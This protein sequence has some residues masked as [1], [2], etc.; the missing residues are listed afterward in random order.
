MSVPT[1]SLPSVALNQFSD[2]VRAWFLDTF[3]APTSLQEQ[4]WEAIERGE[5]ALVIAPTGSGKTLAAFLFAIDSLM[6]EKAALDNA[7]EGEPVSKDSCCT[8]E[9]RPL[10]GVRVVY[11]SPLKALGADVER[12]L[13]DPL[14]GIVERLAR[15]GVK[16]PPIR[17][18]MRTGD[19]TPVQRRSIVRNPPDILITT[20]ESLYLMLTSQAREVLRSVETVIVDEVHALAGNKR[21]AHLALSLERLDDLLKQPAQRI[22]LSATVRPREEVAHFLGGP[23]VVRVVASEVKPDMDVRVSVPVRD[24]TA[25]PAFQ[26][27]DAKGSEGTLPRGL[28]SQGGRAGGIRHIPAEA[29]W[30]SDRTLRAAMDKKLSS[31]SDSRV[32]SSSIWPYI[33]SAILDEVLAHRSTIVFVNSRGL[34]EKLTARLNE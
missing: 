1:T 20:P 32:G 24:M 17:T 2:A 23:H 5:N 16:A 3:A 7:F 15:N 8:T 30:K 28:I 31:P 33:E 21:G 27:F 19:T 14:S 13:Q 34:C 12:N 4:A 6:R 10:K 11:I 9:T 25:I 22:G 18:G 29:A 26:G